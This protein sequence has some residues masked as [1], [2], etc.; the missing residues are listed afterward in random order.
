MDRCG[1]EGNDCD[2]EVRGR[3]GGAG[4]AVRGPALCSRLCPADALAAT[5]RPFCAP[6]AGRM[7]LANFPY[8]FE[9]AGD[10]AVSD[11]ERLAKGS[12][13]VLYE[14]GRIRRRSVDFGRIGRGRAAGRTRA[15]PPT[16]PRS[17]RRSHCPAD[18]PVQQ[19]RACAR[20]GSV[21]G[22]GTAHR[23]G[24]SPSPR[25]GRGCRG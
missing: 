25:A 3:L 24:A 18:S 1:A 6:F 13:R 10:F 17:A 11:S 9:I 19:R 12:S 14:G 7:R 22:S 2:R 21:A 8:S 23:R 16:V 20:P 4:R 15:A 5:G